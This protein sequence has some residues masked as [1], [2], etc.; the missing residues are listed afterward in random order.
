M[1]KYIPGSFHFFMHY[2]TD[3]GMFFHRWHCHHHLN[4]FWNTSMQ[5]KGVDQK[6][7]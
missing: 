5:W 2:F 4:A 6:A 7:Q 3:S 1:E